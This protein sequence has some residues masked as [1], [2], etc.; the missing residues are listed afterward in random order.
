MKMSDIFV[1][2]EHILGSG[3][4]RITPTELGPSR[5]LMAERV[6]HSSWGF[7]YYTI[8]WDAI[9]AIMLTTYDGAHSA[10]FLVLTWTVET[11]D[12]CV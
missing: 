10:I 12:E 11:Y 4:F 6:Q 2:T 8:C 5:G 3:K 9:V 1:F 7:I